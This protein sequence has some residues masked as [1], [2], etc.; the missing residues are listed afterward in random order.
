MSF[1]SQRTIWLA[2]VLS[3]AAMMGFALYLQYYKYLMPCPLCIFQ[4]VW[5]MAA[6]LVA[7]AGIAWNPKT[8]RGRGVM[9]AG[10]L[11]TTLIGGGIAV[12]HVVLQHL[13]PDQV[14]ECGPGLNFMLETMPFGD[15]VGTVLRGTGECA[16]IDWSLLGISLP[17]WSILGFAGLLVL[18]ALA[19]QRGTR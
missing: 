8:R 14:P 12:R 1:V 7:L 18:F 3:V 2:I 5:F 9:L 10:G 13:P 4:R 15:V 6:G 11:L 16:R 19:F 17:G